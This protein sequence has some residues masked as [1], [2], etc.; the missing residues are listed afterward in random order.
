MKTILSS[1]RTSA[2]GILA[3]ALALASI[4]AP[5]QYQ[6]KIQATAAAIG[7]S[8]LLVAKDQ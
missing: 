4:W 2:L 8:G 3:L 5:P 7:A 1:P 6:Q